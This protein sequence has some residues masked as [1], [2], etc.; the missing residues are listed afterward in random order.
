MAIRQLYHSLHYQLTIVIFSL[1]RVQPLG[2]P[3]VLGVV[4]DEHVV[5]HGQ[6]LTLHTGLG[7]NDHLEPPHVA[8][9]ASILQ[10]VL[11]TLQEEFQEEPAMCKS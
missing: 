11:V 6:Q 4:V 9:V 10:A 3:A 1:R 7:G 5:R 8:R 2:P